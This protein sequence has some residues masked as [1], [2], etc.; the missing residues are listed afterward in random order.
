MRGAGLPHRRVVCLVLLSKPG[1]EGGRGVSEGGREVSEG[2]RG[3][4]E[5]VCERVCVRVCV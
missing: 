4:R 3:V 1:S 5:C 2:A